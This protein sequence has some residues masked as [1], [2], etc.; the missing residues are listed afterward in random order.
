MARRRSRRSSSNPALILFLGAAGLALALL[1]DVVRYLWP[2]LLIGSAGFIAWGV[3]A[4]RKRRARLA[5]W[6]RI[7]L[8]RSRE[9]ATY[10][11]M[12]AR[13]FE[14]ALAYLCRRDGCCQV[15]VVGGA[16]DL[17][18][19]II[20]STPDG[21]RLVIQA[22]RYVTGNAVTGP[23]VQKFAGT[24]RMVH[25]AEIGAVVTTSSFTRQAR[26]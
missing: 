10:H 15:Q 22:K 4:G 6:E 9:L 20:A 18:A 3:Q 13:E 19:D 21:R 7:R 17:G 24:F 12:S 2:L 1:V 23:D 11:G 26:E 5:E 8:I 16:G 25:R 14:E